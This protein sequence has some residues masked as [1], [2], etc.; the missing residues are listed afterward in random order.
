MQCYS[1]KTEINIDGK[2][3]RRDTCP[4]CAAYLHCCLTCRFYDVNAHNQCREPQAEWVQNKEMGNF[5][6]Y[7][8]P[9]TKLADKQSDRAAEA[10]K[11]LGELF[12]K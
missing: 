5:C 4:N 12:K 9:A 6:D 3:G 1:C 11:K 2:P 7:F 10:R 8:E